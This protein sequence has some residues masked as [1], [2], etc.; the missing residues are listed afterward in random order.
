M[1]SKV[2]NIKCF[3]IS[4]KATLSIQIM[5]NVVKYV[6]PKHRQRPNISETVLYIHVASGYYRLQTG[7]IVTCIYSYISPCYDNK[8]VNTEKQKDN[9]IITQRN[10]I[11]TKFDIDILYLYVL[12]CP[13]A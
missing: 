12:P 2:C 7:R 10:K 3:C 1:L 4:P 11:S 8:K 9:A 13:A 6:P 5:L